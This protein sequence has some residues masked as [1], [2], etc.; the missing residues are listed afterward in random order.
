MDG[1]TSSD[2]A[3]G[4]RPLLSERIRDSLID[5]IATG[6]LAPGSNLDEQQLATQYGASRTPV[7]EALRQLQTSALVEIVGRRTLVARLTPVR[8]MEMFEAMAEI[9][10]V[11]V[12]LATYRMTPLERSALLRIH[13]ATDVAVAA[14]D[15]DGY[16]RLNRE[17]HEA[18]YK[19]THNTFLEEQALSVRARLSAFRRVQLRQQGRLPRSRGEHDEVLQAINEGD[20]ETAARRMRAHMLSAAGALENYLKDR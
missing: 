5:A 1:Q 10:S 8:I 18:L 17:F 20:G 6:Q 4:R 2:E 7:R 15:V 19:A 11:C 12:R 3:G 9:E 13:E 16:D 14:G